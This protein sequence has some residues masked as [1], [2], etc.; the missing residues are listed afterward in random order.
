MDK[1]AALFGRQY[2]LFDY[3]G[4]PDAERVIVCMGS[5]SGVVEETVDYLMARGE[6]VGLVKV[7]LFRPF[8]KTALLAAIPKSVK[9]IAVLDRTKEPGSNGEPLYQDVVTAMAESWEGPPCR[10]SSAAA[11]A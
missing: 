5:G 6:K 10:R 7:H 2:H 9:K 1:F 11:T 4:A 3:V 8:D